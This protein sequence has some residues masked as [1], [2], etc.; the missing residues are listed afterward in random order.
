M[1]LKNSMWSFS[2]LARSVTYWEVF[3]NIAL[4]VTQVPLALLFI[5]AGGIK[6]FAY[7][8]YK[9]VSERRGPSGI[10]RGLAGFIGTAELVGAVGLVV[11]LAVHFAWWLAAWAALGLATVML[12]AVIYHSPRRQPPMPSAALLVLAVLLAL[13][14]LS[15]WS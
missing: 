8:R 7:E 3:M 2:I 12:L 5:G 9:A 11:P 14:R 10:T 6:V 1:S 4:W 13:G 15:H